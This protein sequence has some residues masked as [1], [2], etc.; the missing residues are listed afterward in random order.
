MKILK[1]TL[2]TASALKFINYNKDADEII[3]AINANNKD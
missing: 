3:C 2:I 1:L